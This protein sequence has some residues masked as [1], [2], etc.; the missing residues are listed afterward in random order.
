MRQLSQEINIREARIE[1]LEGLTTLAINFFEVTPYAQSTE[2]SLNQLQAVLR[3]LIEGQVDNHSLLLVI[4]QAGSL[5][6]M[7]AGIQQKAIF[8]EDMI[9]IELFWW[10]NPSM[11]GTRVGAEMADIY[12]GWAIDSGCKF[13]SMCTIIELDPEG[14]LTNYM[15]KRGFL[16]TE[17]SF[18]R[19]I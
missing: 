12:Q 19:P 16:P 14:R 9:A 8:S 4:E 15:L 2:Y 6:G 17:Q 11:R 10:L 13:C 18:M 7:L 3:G 1:D 5:E